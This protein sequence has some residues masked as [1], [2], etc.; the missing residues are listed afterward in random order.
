MPPPPPPDNVVTVRPQVGPQ[1]TFA[2]CAADIAFYG[3]AAGGGKSWSLLLEPLYHVN[4]PQFG[5]VLFRRTHPEI[6]NEGGLWDESMKL[7]PKAGA[8]PKVGDLSWSFPS[9]A[10]VSFAHMQHERDVLKWHSSQIA[11]IEFD[12]LTTFTE[13]QFTYM[14]SRNRSTCGV[15]PYVRGGCN[16][17]AA[18]WVARWVEWFIDPSTGLPIPERAGRI[19][20]L[21]RDGETLRWASDP[22]ELRKA[23]PDAG[24]PLSFTFV[25]ATLDD[26]KVLLAS[27]PK[28]RANLA[29]LP[30]VERER[31]LRGNW[32]VSA[33]E[34]EWP[35]EYFGRHLWFG[36]WPL[37]EDRTICGI[38][39][40]P[41]KGTDSKYGDYQAFTILMRDR[42]GGL[43]ADAVGAQNWPVEEAIDVALELIRVWNPDTFAVEGN[44]FQHLI[45]PLLVKRAAEL[46]IALT[47][48][49]LIDNR[50]KKEVRIRR[51]GGYLAN[52]TLRLKGNSTGSRIMAEQLM[53]FPN[54]E[55][56]DFPDS[57]EMNFRTLI[58]FWNGKPRT[59][60]R[61]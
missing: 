58:D 24:E 14:L 4:N 42:Y 5:A 31:L 61:R 8:V 54:G 56:D 33:A 55:H 15:R 28:Y 50:V 9:G 7:Y 38:A 3:G 22:A 23:Y 20:Y 46:G 1:E 25:P 27:D 16:P 13:Y 59:P 36:D 51:L 60:A 6:T 53:T 30:R 17:D 45:K 10:S 37:A 39:W 11:L 41:S 48:V 26:N 57:L 43:F 35:A 47:P 19:R 44:T 32:L 40:D 18:S 34:G 29:A 52:R 21:I 12:E 49:K 2:A